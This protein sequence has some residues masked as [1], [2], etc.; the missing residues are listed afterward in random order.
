MITRVVDGAVDGA[1]DATFEAALRQAQEARYHGISE[2]VA[3]L[4]YASACDVPRHEAI[5]EIGSFVGYSTVFLGM[6]SRAGQG[7]MIHC[8]DAWGL[9]PSSMY[10]RDAYREKLAITNDTFAEFLTTITRAGVDG[11]VVPHQAYS[12][13]YSRQWPAGMKIRLLFIDGD[14]SEWGA[15]A[16]WYLYRPHLADGATVVFHDYGDPAVARAVR[17]IDR[18]MMGQGRTV[19]TGYQGR[20]AF[21][22]SYRHQD[23]TSWR[24]AAGYLELSVWRRCEP[25]LPLKTLRRLKHRIMDR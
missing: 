15:Y 5:V 1:K 14:H 6:G 22:F 11:L 12:H 2:P 19:G 24:A 13:Q 10:S 4:L 23:R 21:V 3:R 20:E 16:D 17:R 18:R 7:A 9:P 25:Y 8:L